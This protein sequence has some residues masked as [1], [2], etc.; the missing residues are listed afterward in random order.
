MPL[1]GWSMA[2]AVERIVA[3][4]GFPAYKRQF[5]DQIRQALASSIF[6][7]GQ[8]AQPFLRPH[9]CPIQP[10]IAFRQTMTQPYQTRPAKTC[11]LPVP[12]WREMPIQKLWNACFLTLRHQYRKIVH[13]FCRYVQSVYHAVSLPQLFIYSP[14][15][16]RTM[17]LHCEVFSNF[18]STFIPHSF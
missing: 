13:L 17:R 12:V 14:G 3:G 18:L 6:D 8:D 5:L 1:K 11:P 7:Q 10:V 9:L 2:S 15:F 16:D 4:L